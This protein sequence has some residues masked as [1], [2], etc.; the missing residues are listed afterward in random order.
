[1]GGRECWV[2]IDPKATT[3]KS[4]KRSLIMMTA[5]VIISN[6]L[7]AQSYWDEAPSSKKSNDEIRTV[8]KSGSV[9]GYGAI[10]NK[11]TTIHGEFANMPEIYGGVFIGKKFLIGL[12]GSATTN[13]IKVPEGESAYPELRMSYLYGQ[14]GLVHEWIIA[15]NSPVHVV[16][17]WF[18]G[19]GFELQYERNYHD[20]YD[21]G[22]HAK[23]TDPSWYFVT[24][25]GIQLELNLFKWM[26]LSPG[27]SYRIVHNTKTDSRNGDLT[28]VSGNFTLKF[29]KF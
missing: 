7:C 25:P 8:F 12:G 26:R 21:P 4:I 14:A 17:H 20:A 19:A 13:Y 23:S 24:E 28:G 3:M 18:N 16:F 22:Y 5:M 27:V 9:G 2:V 29:G 10:S 1:M 15:S 6:V 11:F